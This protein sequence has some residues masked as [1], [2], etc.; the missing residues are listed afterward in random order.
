[1][2][3]TKEI[4]I[5]TNSQNINHYRILGYKCN[6]GDE[7]LINIDH[8]SKGSNYKIRAICDKCGKEKELIYNKYIKNVNNGGYYSCS[9]K[10]S[11]DKYINNCL[12]KYGVI[13]I[14]QCIDT[15]NKIK[16][17]K[18]ERYGNDKYNNVKKQKETCLEKYG[19]ENYFETKEFKVKTGVILD[20]DIDGWN[21]YKRKSRRIFRK[22]K[23]IIFDQWNGFDYYDNE[24]IKENFNLP[25]YHNNY[26]TVDHKLSVYYGFKNNISVEH[27]N[28]IE[29]LVI[30]KRINNSIKGK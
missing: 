6:P 12:N 7:I 26:P 17:I 20:E 28:S 23:N 11:K 15:I 13:N 27:I 24:Y 21:L 30:T 10:C 8:L 1:M 18:L 29:N 3:V 14:F 4:K 9:N 19:F 22:N 16:K 25:F 5:K 2:I